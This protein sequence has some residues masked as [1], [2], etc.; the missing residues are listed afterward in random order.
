MSKKNFNI[1][2]LIFWLICVSLILYG[3][4]TNLAVI[5]SF[6]YNNIL[7]IFNIKKYSYQILYL[8]LLGLSILIIWLIAKIID[9][10]FNIK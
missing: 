9:E 5:E 1:L 2:I 4:I 6:L 10:I 8:S 3:F 7:P